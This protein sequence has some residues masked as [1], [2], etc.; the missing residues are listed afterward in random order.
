MT[1]LMGGVLVSPMVVVKAMPTAS[2]PWSS[3]NVSVAVTVAR[4]SPETNSHNFTDNLV[5]K[6]VLPSHNVE[7][8]LACDSVMTKQQSLI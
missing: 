7:N 3:V 6:D 5:C 1:T 4:V 8:G 2:H